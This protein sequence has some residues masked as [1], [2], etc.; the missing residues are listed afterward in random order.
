V[1]FEFGVVATFVVV[2]LMVLNLMAQWRFYGAY[3]R[4]YGGADDRR[5]RWLLWKWPMSLRD[6]YRLPPPWS[7]STLFRPLDDPLVE[8]RRRQLLLSWGAVFAF[9]LLGPIV[10]AISGAYSRQRMTAQTD[11]Y[12]STG[13]GSISTEQAFGHD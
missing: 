1:P 13:S 5:R 8:R 10:V 3:L 9:V 7:L 2:A 4:R 6:V 12:Q 11:A